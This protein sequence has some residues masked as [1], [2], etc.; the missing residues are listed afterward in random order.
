MELHGGAGG[1]GGD[2][3][4]G[5]AQPLDPLDVERE[6]LA[7]GGHDLVVEKAVAVDVGEIGGDQIITGEG[8]QNSDHD[9]PGVQLSG[10][11]VGIPEADPQ[12]LGQPVQD[13]ITQSVGGDIH[14]EIEHSQLGLEIAAGDPLQHL[15]VHH[16][17]QAVGAREIEFDL[18]A[19]EVLRTVEALLVQHPLQRPLALLKFA[20]ERMPI[21]QIER[22]RLDLLAH[23][24]PPR[25]TG[26]R[27]PPRAG[28]RKMMPRQCDP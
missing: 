2:R 28:P 15:L 14:F 22:S 13:A 16:S 17:R 25:G 19:Q 24:C 27:L 26:P 12:L 8:R 5:V 21:R 4:G 20:P 18:Q 9:D 11:T 10:F 6:F 7:P 23:R 3:R 1:L